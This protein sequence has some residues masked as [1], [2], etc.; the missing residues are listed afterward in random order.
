[1]PYRLSEVRA[2]LDTLGVSPKKSL[3]QNFLIDGNV[4][5]KIV[6]FSGVKPGDLVIE[7]GPGLGSLTEKLLERGCHV[8]AIEKDRVFA[9][10][11]EERR[12]PL[13]RLFC[14]DVLT[15]PFREI[16]STKVKIVGNLPYQITTPIF[17]KIFEYS[18]LFESCTFMIQHEVAVR[19]LAKPN[20]KDFSSL[21]L[22]LNYFSTPKWG[23]TVSASCFYPVPSVESAVIGLEI[24]KRFPVQDEQAFFKMTRLAFCHKRKMLASSLREMVP[25]AQIF[26]ALTKSGLS[27]KARP[28]ELS[29]EEWVRFFDAFSRFL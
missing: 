13:L 15:F 8:I 6:N 20:T 3:S 14:Q 4:L 19:C 7:I 26:D 29:I 1:M 9:R 2:L 25:Q 28:Q 5:D 23:F 12:L 10:A 16:L 22:F 18:D 27:L 24:G 17:E 21:T 11:L